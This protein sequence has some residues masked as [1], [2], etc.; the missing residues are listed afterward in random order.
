MQAHFPVLALAVEDAA[1]AGVI[2]TAVQ[3]AAQ[4]AD[5]F[6]TGV[7]AA[8]CTTLPSV[9]GLHPLVAPLVLAVGFYAFVEALA[10]RRGFDPDTPPHLRKVT[11][12]V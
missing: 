9:K 10:R 2:Q 3:L 5:V 4:G 7:E 11:E 1:Q 12:T 6:V 8:G